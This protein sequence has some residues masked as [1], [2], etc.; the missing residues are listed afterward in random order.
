MPYPL[1]ISLYDNRYDK[2]VI[3]S[4][5]V[6]AKDMSNPQGSASGQTS[7]GDVVIDIQNVSDNGS[8]I[9]VYENYTKTEFKLDISGPATKVTL[10]RNATNI[11]DIGL[12]VDSNGNEIYLIP[13]NMISEGM[14]LRTYY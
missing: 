14:Y 9:R 3:S 2:N 4:A 13:E 8:I 12:D 1:F 5:W 10:Y 6:Y 7:S 11:G